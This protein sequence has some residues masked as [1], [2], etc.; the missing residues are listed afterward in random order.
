LPVGSRVFIGG[1]GWKTVGKDKIDQGSSVWVDGEG[2][3]SP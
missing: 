3:V 2:W 1:E